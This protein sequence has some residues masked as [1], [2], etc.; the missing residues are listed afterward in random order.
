MAALLSF[1]G[2]AVGRIF[3]DKV[4]GYIALKLLLVLLLTTVVP[5]ILNNFLYDIMEI[6]MNFATGQAGGASSMNGTMNF[7]GFA[8]WLIS[9]FKLPE[10]LSVMVSALVL[11]LSLSMIPMVRL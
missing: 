7:S 10:C 8:A 9:C 5:L 6:V 1:L 4:L 11:R 2:G 3:S